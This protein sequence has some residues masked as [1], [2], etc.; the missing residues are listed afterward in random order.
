MLIASTSALTF[1]V[2][3]TFKEIFT[4]MWCQW[5]RGGRERGGEGPLHAR[6]CVLDVRMHALCSDP[7]AAAWGGACTSC[8]QDMLLNVHLSGVAP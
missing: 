8:H 3:G 7:E 2:A 5:W 4:G 6:V 1:M